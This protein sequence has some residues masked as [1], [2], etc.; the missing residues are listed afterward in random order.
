MK[1]LFLDNKVNIND[2]MLE[3]FESF[4]KIL[5]FYNEKFN[6]TTITEKQEVY[7]KHF[8]DSCF[9]GSYF[10]DN[11]KVIEIGS[12]GGFPSIPLKIIRPDLKFTLVESTGK[13]C[14]FLK[15]ALKELGFTDCEVINAR[16]EDVGKDS[17]YREK[18]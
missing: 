6:I 13:K 16:A 5:L 11:S 2:E 15:E 10:V 4:R 17:S 9:A 3:K 8:L 18:L 14:L 7:V 1:D 12:G